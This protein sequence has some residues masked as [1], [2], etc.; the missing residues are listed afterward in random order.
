MDLAKARTCD[1]PPRHARVDTLTYW[2]H[3]TDYRWAV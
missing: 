1:V 3:S 2:G